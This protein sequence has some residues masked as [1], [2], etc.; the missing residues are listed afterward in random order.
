[1]EP[2]DDSERQQPSPARI[3]SAVQT[4]NNDASP[5]LSLPDDMLVKILKRLDAAELTA[6]VGPVCKRLYALVTSR[7]DLYSRISL[8]EVRAM[9]VTRGEERKGKERREGEERRERRGE[10]GER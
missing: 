1:M 3:G 8:P 7:A 5:L 2:T 9:C 6:R 4:S 10:K